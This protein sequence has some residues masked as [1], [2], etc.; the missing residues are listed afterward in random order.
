MIY[1][2]PKKLHA[3]KEEKLLKRFWD[4]P[5]P[6]P[7]SPLNLD[8]RTMDKLVLDKRPPGLIASPFTIGFLSTEN[9]PKVKLGQV[10]VGSNI[11]QNHS[12]RL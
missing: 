12:S 5:L 8:G 4:R 10:E 7:L 3:K 6:P 1:V 11:N 2:T 9:L